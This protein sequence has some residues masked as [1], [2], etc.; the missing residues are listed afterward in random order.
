VTPRGRPRQRARLIVPVWGRGYTDRFL[1]LTLPA[2][3]APG[4]LPY[5]SMALDTEVVLVTQRDLFDVIR[6]DQSFRQLEK[7]CATKLVAMDDLMSFP[8]Y[9]GL[10]ITW[11]LFRGFTDL[12]EAMTETWLL[13]MNSDFILADGS[14]RSLA[15]RLTD[16]AHLILAPSYCAIEEEVLPLLRE[17]LDPATQTLA[18]PPR[19]LADLLLDRLHYTVRAKTINRR[20]FR[21]DRVDQFYYA[22]DRD[23]LVGRQFPIAIVAMRPERVLTDP[24]SIWDYGTI[25]EACPTSPLE[26]LADSD[27]FL[28]LELRGRNVAAEQLE[29][30]WLDPSTIARDHSIWTTADQRRC[31]EHTLILHRGDLPPHL[32]QGVRALAEFHARVAAEVCRP[33]LS[34]RD[35]PIWNRLQTLHH[36]WRAA[37]GGKPQEDA[38]AW[39]TEASRHRPFRERLALAIR[40]VY[41]SIFGRVPWVRAGHPY[42]VDLAPATALIED[43]ATRTGCAVAVWST[44]RA[45]LAPRLGEWFADV[46]EYRPDEL[47]DD[48]F[49]QTAGDPVDFCFVELT[50]DEML[51]L[52]R[53]HPRLRRLMR[54][55]GHIVVFYRTHGIETL[56]P[57]DVSFIVGASLASDAT[58]VWFRGSRVLH[59]LQRL[60]DE[61]LAGLRKRRRIGAVWFVITALLAAPVTW[62]ASRAAQR[63]TSRGEVPRGCTSVL[64]DVTVL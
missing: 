55:G 37:G 57:R 4:N 10:T 32:G 31:G 7:H 61:R 42:W 29:L 12:G 46:R 47:L 25:S 48:H 62:L 19:A 40:G 52:R 1:E 16:Q 20:M 45:L 8:A 24:V 34:H 17:H 5:L 30:G 53:L 6:A 36:E 50:R 2:L 51:A 60:W 39:A 28:M 21:I 49:R 13:F 63:R 64:M 33:P 43:A 44:P 38:H 15:P 26:V 54:R 22:V 41:R 56:A 23:T 9:Y 35:H 59:G 58:V 27:D 14:Y 11:S 3:L 18:I